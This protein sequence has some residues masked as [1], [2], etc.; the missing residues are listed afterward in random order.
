MSR[1][2]HRRIINERTRDIWGTNVYYDSDEC[3]IYAFFEDNIL[4]QNYLLMLNISKRYPFRPPDTT[5]NNKNI[6]DFYASLFSSNSSTFIK[7]QQQELFTGKCLCCASILCKNNWGPNMTIK[8]I[9]DEF[10]EYICLKK[11]ILERFWLRSILRIN[12]IPI[13]IP[14]LDYL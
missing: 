3:K 5:V 9:L 6:F 11:R 8:S 4:S 1:M 12:N 13:E 10:V 14:I 7:Q 2:P